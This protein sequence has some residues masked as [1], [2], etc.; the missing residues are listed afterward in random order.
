MSKEVY[1]QKHISP[2][3]VKVLTVINLLV[4]AS[5]NIPVVKDYVSKYLTSGWLMF[6]SFTAVG[7]SYY[8]AKAYIR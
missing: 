1:L 3:F 5:V 6:A 7:L 8:V 4:L 2:V